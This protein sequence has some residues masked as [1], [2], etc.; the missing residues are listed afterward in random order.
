MYSCIAACLRRHFTLKCSSPR[1]LFCAWLE[2]AKIL[3]LPLAFAQSQAGLIVCI[4]VK[5][6]RSEY[7]KPVVVAIGRLTF[8]VYNKGVRFAICRQISTFCGSDAG[9]CLERARTAPTQYESRTWRSVKWY[10][11]QKLEVE[12]KSMISI[13]LHFTLI[14][15]S[16]TSC[17]LIVEYLE[18]QVSQ[19]YFSVCLCLSLFVSGCLCLSLFDSVCLCLSMFVSVC[20]CLCLFLSVCLRLSLFVSVCLCLSLSVSVC[21]CLS[22]FVSDI[23]FCICLSLS[24]SVYLCLSLFHSAC[25]CVSLIVRIYVCL[26]LSLSG[27]CLSLLVPPTGTMLQTQQGDISNRVDRSC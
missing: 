13:S 6:I 24:V 14:C 25:L 16:S 22:L 1:A 17:P 23:C 4:H 19:P 11:K 18:A 5:M 21:L 10:S 3:W 26:C 2:Y 12:A 27:L 15:L 7:A 20:L 9:R 8:I